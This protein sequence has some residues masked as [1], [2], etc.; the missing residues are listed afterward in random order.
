VKVTAASRDANKQKTEQAKGLT[1]AKISIDGEE[2]SQLAITGA[3][4]KFVGAKASMEGDRVVGWSDEVPEPKEVRYA[5]A[6]N[7]DGANLCNKEALPA[8]V[9]RTDK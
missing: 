7:P 3:N 4:K 9:F 8:S 1:G 6:D 5:W 2:L